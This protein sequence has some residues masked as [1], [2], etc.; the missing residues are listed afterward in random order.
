MDLEAFKRDFHYPYTDCLITD[1]K[2]CSLE[3][4]VFPNGQK[5]HIPGCIGCKSDM[6]DYFHIIRDCGDPPLIEIVTPV[7]EGGKGFRLL[8]HVCDS[9]ICANAKTDS[10]CGLHIHVDANTM[11]LSQILSIISEYQ[12]LEDDIDRRMVPA[13]RGNQC[14]FAKGLGE[15]D[16]EH[17]NSLDKLLSLMSDRNRKVNVQSLRK[18]GTLEFRQHHGSICYDEIRSWLF[19]IMSLCEK[20]AN[21]GR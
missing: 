9:L 16:F 10:R 6:K 4:Y 19:F 7:L 1:F 2:D 13:R 5:R 21:G 8:H 17:V 15:Y 11:S 18:Y 20:M 3:G 14:K 12:R